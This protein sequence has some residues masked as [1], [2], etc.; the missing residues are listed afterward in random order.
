M[1]TFMKHIQTTIGH[2][3][4]KLNVLIRDFSYVNFDVTYHLL[5]LFGSPLWHLH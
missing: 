1:V 2:F 5:P 3:Y 4:A